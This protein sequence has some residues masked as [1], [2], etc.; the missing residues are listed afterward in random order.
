MTPAASEISFRVADPHGPRAQ[1]EN[2]LEG[3]DEFIRKVAKRHAAFEECDQILRGFEHT[4]D[5]TARLLFFVRPQ[6]RA[7]GRCALDL[8][9]SADPRENELAIS[10]AW[11]AR[12]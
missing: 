3:V 2:F 7:D 4:R 1:R 8:A 10:L 5:V 6:A 12:E 11:A 9:M